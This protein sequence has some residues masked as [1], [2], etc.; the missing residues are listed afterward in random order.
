MPRLR[1]CS[2]TIR[3]RAMAKKS[4]LFAKSDDSEFAESRKWFDKNPITRLPTVAQRLSN[5]KTRR[6]PL[7]KDRVLPRSGQDRGLIRRVNQFFKIQCLLGW[8]L[9]CHTNIVEN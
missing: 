1:N 5:H 2:S 4:S 3:C 7:K 6:N 9:Y 8:Q